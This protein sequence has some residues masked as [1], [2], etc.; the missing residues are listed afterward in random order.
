MLLRCPAT[1][2]AER[3]TSL[4]VHAAL[5]RRSIDY[6]KPSCRSAGVSATPKWLSTWNSAAAG[7][8]GGFNGTRL[9][10][11][12]RTAGGNEFLPE[13]IWDVDLGT[14]FAGSPAGIP[15]R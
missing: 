13:N 5:S 11:R 10:Y 2:A 15:L 7:V 3:C 4:R 14:K 6:H 1:I 8:A 12:A 9:Q